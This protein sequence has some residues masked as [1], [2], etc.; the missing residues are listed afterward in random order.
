MQVNPT[1][2]ING[3]QKGR[4]TATHLHA[5]HSFK[6]VNGESAVTQSGKILEVTARKHQK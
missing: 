5:K 3:G 1:S 6:Q 4:V 2:G